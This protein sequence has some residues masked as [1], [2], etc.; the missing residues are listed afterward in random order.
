VKAVIQRVSR[1]TC[2]V[3]G[4]LVG[5][6]GRGLL[7]LVCAMRGDES[8]GARKLARRIAE[9]RCFPDEE[10]RMNLSLVDEGLSLLVVSQFTLAADGRRGRRP[11]FVS[12]APPEEAQALLED[13]L[14]EFR[15][16]GL[17]CACGRFGAHMKVELLNDGPVTFVLE[18]PPK[19]PG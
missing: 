11:S 18:V 5:E 6:V 15:G 19:A 13:F 10:G 4:C 9:F 8:D 7:V 17:E 14:E 2:E 16:L 12:A 3:D 1:A